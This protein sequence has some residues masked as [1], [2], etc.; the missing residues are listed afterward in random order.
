[1]HCGRR[2]LVLLVALALVTTVASQAAGAGTSVTRATSL[3][4]LVLQELNAVRT[5]RGVQ[6]LVASAALS[7]A[8]IGHAR[9][10]ATIGF[11]S[12]ESHDGTRFSERIRQFYGPHMQPW[13]VGEN[14]AMFGGATPTAK[15]I[16]A[17]W[18]GSPAHRAN[19]LRRQFR[20]AGVAI[21]YH[22]AAG[23]VFGGLP[24]WV[25]TLDVGCR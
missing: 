11:F 23:G 6:P 20:D 25:V 16:V 19:V 1:M 15:A 17:A 24:T 14:L 3:E 21:V 5:A 18:M 10:M 7:R 13:T 2:I 4:S 22:P 8:A 12:H 9:S